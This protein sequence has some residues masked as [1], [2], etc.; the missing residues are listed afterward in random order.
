MKENG[1][2]KIYLPQLPMDFCLS[3]ENLGQQLNGDEMNMKMACN[4]LVHV[5]KCPS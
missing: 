5:S 1:V 4:D 2:K 3:I